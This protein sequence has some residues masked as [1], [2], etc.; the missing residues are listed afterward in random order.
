VTQSDNSN[1][2]KKPGINLCSTVPDI[3]ASVA[4]E[5]ATPSEST[6]IKLCSTGHLEVPG[7]WQEYGDANHPAAVSYRRVESFSTVLRIGV[8]HLSESSQLTLKDLCPG[9]PRAFQDIELKSL[10]EALALTHSI[11]GYEIAAASTELLSGRIV[12]VILGFFRSTAT[13]EAL[14]VFPLAGHFGYLALQAIKPEFA[15]YFE[16]FKQA[17]KTIVWA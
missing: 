12:L 11:E 14:V 13:K 17:L 3:F 8:M 16:H 2:R 6:T 5:N 4:A 15:V 7:V 10:L 1:L 9:N